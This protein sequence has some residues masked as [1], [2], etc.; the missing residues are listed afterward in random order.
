MD[1]YWWQLSPQE[2]RDRWFQRFLSGEGISFIGPE[3]EIAYRV[4]AQRIVDVF[5]VREPDRVPVDLLIGTLPLQLAGISMHTA[6][7]EPEK[8]PDNICSL[9]QDNIFFYGA[10]DPEY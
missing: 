5:Q 7:Y 6:M 2:K 1:K 8:I 9:F 4:R 3:A 10:S